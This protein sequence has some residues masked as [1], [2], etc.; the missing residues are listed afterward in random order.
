MN[1]DKRDIALEFAD[2]AAIRTKQE[3]LL[4]KHLR[5]CMENSP[6]YRSRLQGFSHEQFALEDLDQL[7]L[8]DKA[9]LSEDNDAF[10]AVEAERAVDLVFSSGTTGRPTKIIYTE[11]D[12]ARLAENERRSLLACGLTREDVVLLTCTIDRCFIAGLA[13]FSGV[14]ALG[15]TAVRNGLGSLESHAEVLRRSN[16]TVLIG[17]PSFLRKLALYLDDHEIGAK[18]ASVR[19]LVCIGEPVRDADMMPLPVYADLERLWGAAVYSTYASSETITSFCECTAQR[20]GHLLPDL[21]LVEIVDEQG[22][23]R[24][25]GGIG[26]L[27]VTPL[28][29]EGM[30][31]LR[32]RTGDVSFLL[33]EPCACGRRTPRL[34]PILGRKKQLLKVRGTSIYPQAI[35]SVLDD[36][37]YVGEYYIE[38]RSS[39]DL[40]DH[41]IVHLSS[42]QGSRDVAYVV[43]EI[44][45]RIRIK[46]EVLIESEED[47]R[48]VV[49]APRARKPMRFLDRR[50]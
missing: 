45:A 14:R 13:Y 11:A 35:F 30:P 23:V 24:T 38:V 9:D 46:P 16:A 32:F 2:P 47:I 39:G 10:F 41:V 8:T 15:A 21:G 17:V 4:R 20:G 37:P 22:R 44:Q 27:V 1:I 18:T 34:G 6:F 48:R 50:G 12:L 40:S 7:P 28:Q 19:K 26:E 5:Y 31:L 29:I 36:L 43:R 33:D 42:G 3:T 49:F 25:D